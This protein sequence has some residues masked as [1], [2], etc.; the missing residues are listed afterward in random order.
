MRPRL[1]ATLAVCLGAAAVAC[2][3]ILGY[4]DLRVAEVDDGG[5]E[6][7]AAATDASAE[8]DGA[9]DAR[10]VDDA[11]AAADA[12]AETI[13]RECPE[14]LS[15]SCRPDAGCDPLVFVGAVPRD[16]M[17]ASTTGDDALAEVDRLCTGAAKVGRPDFTGP[18]AFR[19]WLSTS[20]R[21][22]VERLGPVQDRPFLRT[23]R[24]V[25]ARNVQA[26]LSGP[27]DNPI[28][29]HIKGNPVGTPLVWTGTRADGGRA[30]TCNDWLSGDSGVPGTV[31]HA[32]ST[33]GR[34]T[35]DATPSCNAA[36]HLYCF[37]IV[38]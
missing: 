30:A 32:N 18:I 14:C 5:Q 2:S 26:L 13:V 35:D 7:D 3:A 15:G 33:G 9:V 23:D 27:L 4:E 11:N 10:P 31:G 8:L 37:E 38:R 1:R 19:A 22:A 20:T 21:S 17:F 29:L 12:D 28:A 24:L 6:S 25:I 34:W 16:G 36:A